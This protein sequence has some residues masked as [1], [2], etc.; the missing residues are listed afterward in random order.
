MFVFQ[1][2]IIAKVIIFYFGV[3]YALRA[4]ALQYV[5]LEKKHYG[6]N[7]YPCLRPNSKNKSIMQNHTFIQWKNSTYLFRW[8]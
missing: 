8:R 3:M 4:K 1:S 6:P 2:V 7:K 5:V